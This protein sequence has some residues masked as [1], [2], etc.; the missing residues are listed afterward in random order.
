MASE[1]NHIDDLIGKYLSH[2]ASAEDRAFVEAW[3]AESETNKRYFQQLSIIFDRA[4][5]V[6]EVQHFDTDQAWEQVK[7]R[8]NNKPKGKVVTLEPQTAQWK[9]LLRIAA[10]AIIVFGLGYFAYT[11]FSPTQINKHQVATVEVTERDT[12]PD[13]S[14]VVLN[15][16]TELAY[17]FNRKTE[18]H[19][20]KL[21]GEA[22]F[23]IKPDAEKKSFVVEADDVLVRD[24]GTAFN[25]KAYP[26]SNTVEVVVEEGEV[27]FY[28]ANNEGVF[29][30]KGGKGIYD[31]RTK[32][33][34]VSHPE[35]NI[36]SYKSRVFTFGNSNLKSVV[37]S[38][39]DVYTQRIVIGDHLHDCRLTVSFNNED[40][41]EIANVIAETLGLTVTVQGD[42]I[43]LEGE[44]CAK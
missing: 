29:V 15:K 19:V 16:R 36:T 22:Y 33:F 38:L 9:T 10:S 44:G 4:A 17:T 31:R 30:K 39:N 35:P 2:E 28:T 14:E 1:I 20:V 25:V 11:I 32:T 5:T 37:E 13:G 43:R 42:E 21:K 6:T 7:A 27:Q 23:T 41:L 3:M 8:L 40:L 18:T 24:I 12:L 26:E 34:S